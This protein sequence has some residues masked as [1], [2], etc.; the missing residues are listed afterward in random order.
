[1]NCK[2][3]FNKFFVFVISLTNN[4][5]AYIIIYNSIVKINYII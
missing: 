4:V 5:Y 2:I 1:M 3:K